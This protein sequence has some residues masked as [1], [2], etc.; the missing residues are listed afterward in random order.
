MTRESLI[1]RFSFLKFAAVMLSLFL[2]F[3]FVS[4][5]PV[6]EMIERNISIGS[7]G[8]MMII[9][10]CLCL[11]SWYLN[12][13][14]ESSL[15]FETGYEWF[16]SRQ[17]EM[18]NFTLY[19]VVCVLGV[20]YV[21]LHYSL[22]WTIISAI[23]FIFLIYYSLRQIVKLN[24]FIERIKKENKFSPV[25]NVVARNLNYWL[26]IA[27]RLAGLGYGIYYLFVA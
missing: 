14:A 8:V 17:A 22:F 11:S 3:R 6:K 23:V 12:L 5:Y 2:I 13:H 7:D 16:Y 18:Q 10:F 26:C 27:V 24:N 21:S 20:K 9:T 4:L 25:E 15:T 1:G 19:F